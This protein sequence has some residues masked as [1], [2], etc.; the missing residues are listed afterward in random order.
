MGAL[1]AAPP[2]NDAIADAIPIGAVP[3]VTTAI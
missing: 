3:F 2:D 1:V